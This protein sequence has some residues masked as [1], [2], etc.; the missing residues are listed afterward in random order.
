MRPAPDLFSTS[1][2]PEEDIKKQMSA[3]AEKIDYHN[4]R[5]Y[6]LN[7]PELSDYEFDQLLKKLEQL[8]K[9]YPHLA[10]PNSP[11][12]RVGGSVT[13]TFEQA[14]HSVPMLSLDNTYNFGEL[15]DWDRRV[16]D[17]SGLQ[18]IEYV[19]ELKIDGVSI[20][21]IYENGQ[22]SKAVTRGDGYRG[23]VVTENVRTIRTLPLKIKTDDA[24]PKSLEV[25]GEIYMPVSVFQQLNKKKRQE[26]EDLGYGEDQIAAQLLKNPRNAAAGTLKLQKSSEVAR[27]RLDAFLY[28]IVIPDRLKPT[29][30][31]NLDQLSAWGF[32]VSSF[33]KVCRGIEEVITTISNWE[34]KREELD[35]E[36]DGVVVKVNPVA[37]WPV[38]GVTAKSPR[39]AVAFK[40]KPEVAKTVLQGVTFQVGRTGAVTPVAELSPVLLSG[41]TVKRATLHNEDFIRQM[42]LHAGDTVLVEKGGEIIP[43]IT[44]VVKE[45]R[46][47]QAAPIQFPRHC[48]EC[49][50]PLMRKPGE[51]AWYCTNEKS[52]RPIILGRLA[53]FVQKKAMDINT[54]GEKTLKD[55]YD[56]G[57]VRNPDDLYRLQE[58]DILKLEG[59]KELSARNIIHG[60]RESVNQPFERVLYALGIRYVGETVAKRLAR[61][62][63]S[64]NALAH[65][66]MDTL[67][68][69][70]DV[71]EMIAESVYSWFR[72]PENQRLIENLRAAGLSMETNV[73]ARASQALTGKSFVVSGVFSVSRDQIK[74]LIEEN[75][76]RL[77]SSVS[78]NTD[79]LLAGEKPGP[80]KMQKAH[81]LGIHIISEN[82]LYQMLE[83]S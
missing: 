1:E 55:L 42:D 17:L 72:K 73:S 67:K 46:P 62:F 64:V 53:H 2:S 56:A 49:G 34:A 20:S 11:T 10:D 77:L 32:Q 66:D 82:D 76:G 28:F 78:K 21:L 40:Y 75:G 22:L 33:R 23:D 69:T 61:A 6:I 36:T 70:E 19:C 74:K 41:T 79:F 37:L 45:L 60:I 31:E 39:W 80:E 18:E 54:L 25:R 43:K 58:A 12:K 63:V 51:A 30:A 3:L 68:A 16:R 9:Q 81:V 5:Y 44:G 4:Y 15:R 24:L 35:Y 26:L 38:L 48:P 7:D 59:Y 50:E 47:A 65:A 8:E 13:K 29:H 27:R 14:E 52:C 71:G 57:L 83:S